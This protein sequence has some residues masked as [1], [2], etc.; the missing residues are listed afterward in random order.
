MNWYKKAQIS[1]Q[2]QK[3]KDEMYQ[4]YKG[5]PIE[6]RKKK[7]RGVLRDVKREWGQSADRNFLQSLATI[8]WGHIED[9]QK[10]LSSIS[11]TVEL[12][13]I[14][15]KS[16]PYKNDWVGSSGIVLKGWITIAAPFDLQTGQG[17]G[18]E[19]KKPGQTRGDQ[20]YPAYSSGLTVDE[21]GF[22]GGKF[23]EVLVDNWTPVALV[24]SKSTWGDDECEGLMAIAKQYNLP[25]WDENGKPISQCVKTEQTE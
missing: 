14:A 2:T 20:K 17:V 13:A 5:L 8:H 19:Y 10:V 22:T 18:S 12:S 24:L 7:Q 9:I 1:E 15:Y 4:K 21:K 11:K 25:V 16:P 3:N 6:E 23:N